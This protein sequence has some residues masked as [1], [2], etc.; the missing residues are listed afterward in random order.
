MRRAEDEHV[1]VV[2][3]DVPLEDL[4]FQLPQLARTIWR[5][6]TPTS[7]RRNFL[8]YFVIHTRCNLM[9]NRVWAVRR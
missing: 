4:D 1:D 5:S 6:R 7:P 9:S 8:R 2:A 3:A